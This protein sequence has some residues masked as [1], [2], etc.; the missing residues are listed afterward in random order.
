M[1][2]PTPPDLLV[3]S[4]ELEGWLPDVAPGSL[5]EDVFTLKVLWGVS[6]LVR[7]AGLASWTH[8]N[9]PD[10]ARLIAQILA[11]NYY[12]HPTGVIADTTGPITERY[13]EAVVHSMELMPEQE[14]ILARLAAEAVDTPGDMG[15]LQTLT[16]TR[17]PVETGRRRRAD[18][19]LRDD[20]GSYIAY[21]DAGDPIALAALG[22]EP[23]GTT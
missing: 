7:D 23:I 4:A 15:P 8:D 22:L 10:R 20:R 17:G 1:T 2:E 3:T 6:V 13:I 14:E 12:E 5:A 9:L 19:F 16:T 11:K 18:L 21:A